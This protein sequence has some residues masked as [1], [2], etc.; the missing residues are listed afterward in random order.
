MNFQGYFYGPAADFWPWLTLY[1]SL[2]NLKITS[3]LLVQSSCDFSAGERSKGV[4]P[5]LLQIL[6][7]RW[8]WKNSAMPR[9]PGTHVWPRWTFLSNFLPHKYLAAVWGCERGTVP[10][11]PSPKSVPFSVWIWGSVY[12]SPTPWMSTTISWWPERSK[13]KWLKAWWI[14]KEWMMKITRDY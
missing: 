7:H 13:E 4:R 5:I 12:R 14:Q 1:L 2:K 10:R 8:E 11:F 9:T 3:S 6:L